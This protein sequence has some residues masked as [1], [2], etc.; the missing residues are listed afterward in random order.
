MKTH[1]YAF[2]AS[3]LLAASTQ[4]LA[5]SDFQQRP[6]QWHVDAG[7]SVTNGRTGE[8]LENGWT[9]GVGLTWWPRAGIPFGLRADLHYS[10]YNATDNFINLGSALTQT[11]VDDGHGEIVGLD[12]DGV[13]EVPLGSIARGYVLAGIGEAYRRIELTQTVV[14]GGLVCDPWWGFCAPGFFPGDVLIARGST[15]RFGWNAGLG[16]DFPLANGSSWFIEARYNRIETTRPT[17][18][19]PIRIGLRF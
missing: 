2:G 12:V 18:F 8:F 9:A 13:Y 15:T 3:M 7:Y 6:L 16:V 4:A 19:I 5:Q 17:Q 14:I 10:D 11:R 1:A